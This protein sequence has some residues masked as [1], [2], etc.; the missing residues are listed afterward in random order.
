MVFLLAATLFDP[1]V[2]WRHGNAFDEERTRIF[3][4]LWAILE[5]ANAI[6]NSNVAGS[7]DVSEA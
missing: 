7:D 2:I 1:V 5:C 4:Q 3:A 6:C